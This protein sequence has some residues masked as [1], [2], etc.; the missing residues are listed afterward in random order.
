LE[1][2][3]VVHWLGSNKPPRRVTVSNTGIVRLRIRDDSNEIGYKFLNLR[4]H[5]AIMAAL[6]PDYK[7]FQTVQKYTYYRGYIR[8][9]DDDNGHPRPHFKQPNIR[10]DLDSSDNPCKASKTDVDHMLGYDFNNLWCLWRCHHS[11][12]TWFHYIRKRE[13]AWL[14]PYVKAKYAKVTRNSAKW[15]ERHYCIIYIYSYM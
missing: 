11:V 7:V 6:D 5:H 1:T 12:N 4:I 9:Y 10:A 8:R 2:G 13:K 3:E 15:K 14:H